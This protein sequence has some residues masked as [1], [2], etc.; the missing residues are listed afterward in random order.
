MRCYH[1]PSQPFTEY[2]TICAWVIKDRSPIGKERS[3]KYTNIHSRNFSSGPTLPGCFASR[4]SWSPPPS[5][6]GGPHDINSLYESFPTLSIDNQH[7]FIQ[8]NIQNGFQILS[9]MYNI[10]NNCL[11]LISLQI[12]ISKAVNLQKGFL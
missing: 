10:Q 11:H 9:K 4:E 3:V 12:F 2:K 1:L 6:R 8:Q 5:L 7:L